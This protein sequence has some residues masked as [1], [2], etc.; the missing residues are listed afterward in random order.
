MAKEME[1]Y[2]WE[3]LFLI[4][5]NDLNEEKEVEPTGGKILEPTGKPWNPRQNWVCEVW[6]ARG[7]GARRGEGGVRGESPG[8]AVIEMFKL[9]E[10][11]YKWSVTSKCEFSRRDI[12]KAE[13]LDYVWR[14]RIKRHRG[15]T[16]WSWMW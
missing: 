10:L 7:A 14:V 13:V 15:Q 8:G 3:D 5:L 2:A 16:S 12:V 6:R 9:L 11:T 4:L 1:P